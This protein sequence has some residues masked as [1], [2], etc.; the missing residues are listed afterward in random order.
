MP[1]PK[2][3]FDE[4]FG[5]N[6]KVPSSLAAKLAPAMA[7]REWGSVVNVSTMVASFGQPGTAALLRDTE[8]QLTELGTQV[9]QYVHR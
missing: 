4:T 1:P 9:P 7:E 6:V 2:K 5:L 3:E 8:A